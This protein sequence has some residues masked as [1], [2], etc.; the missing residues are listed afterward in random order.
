MSSN[1]Q[2][3]NFAYCRCVLLI[4]HALFR[5]LFN[6]Q[7]KGALTF[8]VPTPVFCVYVNMEK[9]CGVKQSDVQPQR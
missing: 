6:L 5:L 2:F 4:A 3:K 1:L 9:T 7:F 8:P